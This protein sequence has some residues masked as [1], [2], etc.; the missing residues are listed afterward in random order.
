M[1]NILVLLKHKVL[2]TRKD[3]KS[4]IAGGNYKQADTM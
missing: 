4:D 1:Q 3:F 2:H